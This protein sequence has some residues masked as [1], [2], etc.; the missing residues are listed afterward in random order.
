MQDLT[1]YN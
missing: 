1:V